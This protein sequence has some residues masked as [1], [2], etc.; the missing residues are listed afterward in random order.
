MSNLNYKVAGKEGRTELHLK[1]MSCAGTDFTSVSHIIGCKGHLAI[2]LC[3]TDKIEVIYRANAFKENSR[4][5]EHKT[6]QIQFEIVK[7]KEAMLQVR[8]VL[9]APQLLTMP[10]TIVRACKDPVPSCEVELMLFLTLRSHLP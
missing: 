5:A 1:V 7:S 2:A 4:S 6:N 10:F 8:F 9:A 3:Q